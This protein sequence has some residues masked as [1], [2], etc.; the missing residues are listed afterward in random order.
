MDWTD[1]G[2]TGIKQIDVWHVANAGVILKLGDFNIGVDILCD[3]I[4]PYGATPKDVEEQVLN[5]DYCPML[6]YIF[7]THEHPDHFSKYKVIEFLTKQPQVKVI[8]NTAVINELRGTVS[9]TRLIS[10]S[11]SNNKESFELDRDVRAYVFYSTHMGSQ[12]K[13]IVNLC[14]IISWK[15]KKILIPGDAE[16]RELLT[17]NL[18][19]DNKIDFMIVPF[20]Y[21]TLNSVRKLVNDRIQP[22]QL[23][24]VHLPDAEHDKG[25]WVSK[26]KTIYQKEAV[27]FPKT[28]FG[29]CP[30]KSYEW[31]W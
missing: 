31:V 26:S 1:E 7:I 5:P 29:E 14:L 19:A 16:P 9:E 28:T 3:Q 24:V 6:D 21:I 11:G 13:K 25:G 15:E 17:G 20:P 30:G 10:V 12:Y 2:M 23:L 27:N 22:E 4:I 18:L 8:S